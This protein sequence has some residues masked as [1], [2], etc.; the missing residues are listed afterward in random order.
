MLNYFLNLR[1]RTKMMAGYAAFG[2]FFMTLVAVIFLIRLHNTAVEAQERLLQRNAEITAKNISAGLDFGD[3]AT[4][5]DNFAA[6]KGTNEYVLALDA[7]GQ[8]FTGYFRDPSIEKDMLAMVLSEN[9]A[10]HKE[11]QSSRLFEAFDVKSIILPVQNGVGNEIGVLVAGVSTE[12]ISSQL[13]SDIGFAVILLLLTVSMGMVGAYIFSN[14]LIKPITGVVERLKDIAEGEGDLTKRISISVDDEIGQLGMAFNGFLDR[15]HDMIKQI[16]DATRQI[17]SSVGAINTITSNVSDGSETQSSQTTLVAVAAE[18]MSATIVQTSSNTSDAVQVSKTANEAVQRGKVVVDDTV[19]GLQRISEVVSES[20]RTILE[21]G[22]TVAQIGTIIEVIN[23]ITDQI[24]LLSLNASIE[25]AS[26]G[27]YGKGFAVV[28]DEV[29]KLAERTTQSTTEITHMIEKTQKAM[30]D[31]VRAM[32]RG[33][34][35]VER[36]REL[37]GKTTEALDDILRA[38][39]QTLEMITNIAVSAQQQSH[40]AEE[41]SRNIEN[42]SA[43]TKTTTQGVR[44]IDDSLDSLIGQTNLLRNMVDRFRLRDDGRNEK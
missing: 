15:L 28:A 41:I 17:G 39:N 1:M 27:E 2:L 44:Q 5:M 10:M 35:E 30:A 32:E 20:A 16:A 34:I 11:G 37:G 3:K 13:R 29:K 7:T 26:A 14:I 31:A 25:A 21:L 24:N 22:R 12:E 33:T 43:I 8:V 40:T 19:S 42:I 23:D 6:V 38:N 18:E 9:E 36:G 4:V